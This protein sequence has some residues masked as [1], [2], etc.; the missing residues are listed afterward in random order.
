MSAEFMTRREAG[1][2]AAELVTHGVAFSYAPQAGDHMI[3]VNDSREPV[4]TKT[5]AVVRARIKRKDA[6]D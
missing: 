1:M 2:V 3:Q 6:G 5:L 4:L